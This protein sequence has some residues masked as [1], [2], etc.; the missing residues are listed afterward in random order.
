MSPVPAGS[1][2]SW[3]GMSCRSVQCCRNQEAFPSHIFWVPNGAGFVFSSLLTA[4]LGGRL[5]PDRF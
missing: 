3:D 4:G 2:V 1:E 5:V